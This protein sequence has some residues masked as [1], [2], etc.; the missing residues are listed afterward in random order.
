MLTVQIQKSLQYGFVKSHWHL[1]H[2]HSRLNLC[3][4]ST[5]LQDNLMQQIKFL[6]TGYQF[7]SVRTPIEHVD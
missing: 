7:F 3:I 5:V 6:L 2:M 1:Q 4:V